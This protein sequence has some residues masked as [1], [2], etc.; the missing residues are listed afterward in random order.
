MAVFSSDPELHNFGGIWQ[1]VRL[2]HDWLISV[3][4]VHIDFLS[5][6]ELLLKLF[7]N[8]QLGDWSNFLEFLLNFFPEIEYFPVCSNFCGRELVDELLLRHWTLWFTNVLKLHPL[9]AFNFGFSCRVVNLIAEVNW[10]ERNAFGVFVLKV[11]RKVAVKN[12]RQH[13]LGL[14]AVIRIEREP[15]DHQAIL[16][17]VDAHIIMLFEA[18]HIATCPFERDHHLFLCYEVK[19][20]DSP[21]EYL[22]VNLFRE[23]V[24]V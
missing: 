22:C 24:P 4:F 23:V 1:H 6:L 12:I 3:Q 13:R 9:L 19:F 14:F 2:R 16:V 5:L 21:R 18:L 10:F 7:T 15:I 11:V 17:E 20:L 8:F